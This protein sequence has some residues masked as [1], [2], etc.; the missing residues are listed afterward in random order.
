MTGNAASF[1]IPVPALADVTAA[2]NGR[3]RL[4]TMR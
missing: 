1:P 2:I 3:N 4:T